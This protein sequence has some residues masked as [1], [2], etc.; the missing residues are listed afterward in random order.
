M[1][2]TYRLPLGMFGIV[3]LGITCCQLIGCICENLWGA[4]LLTLILGLPYGTNLLIS[5]VLYFIL[6]GKFKR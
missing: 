4:N 6:T 1:K 3:F 5:A 2:E